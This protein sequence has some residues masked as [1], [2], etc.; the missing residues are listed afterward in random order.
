[1]AKRLEKLN[2]AR[3]NLI[4][5]LEELKSK[6]LNKHLSIL[7]ETELDRAEVILAARDLVRRLQ[8]TTED[9]AKLQIEEIMPLL[10]AIRVQFGNEQ[11]KSFEDTISESLNNTLD[12]VKRTR[13]V[14]ATAVNNLESSFTSETMVDNGPEENEE[15]FQTSNDEDNSSEQDLEPDEFGGA[16][17]AS[18]EKNEPLGRARKK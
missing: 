13:E 17:G 9:L 11:S 12:S 8:S 18:G 3:E 7:L 14:L 16:E 2:A 15:D 6:K 4:V 1:M 5:K 10:D